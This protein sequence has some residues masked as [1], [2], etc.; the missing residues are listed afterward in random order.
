MCGAIIFGL[1]FGAL[2]LR[3]MKRWAYYHHGCGGGG[4][5][6]GCGGPGAGHGHCGGPRGRRFMYYRWGGAGGGWG[7]GPWG[8]HGQPDGSFAPD[9]PF[10][11]RGAAARPAG[12]PIAEVLRSLELN[13]RQQQEA[14]PVLALAH[15]WLGPSGPRIEAALL[16]VAAE[17]FEPVLVEGLLADA[18]A[19]IQREILDGLEHLHTILISEQRE[20]LRTQLSR[21][22]KAAATSPAPG[23]SGTA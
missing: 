6:H 11:I 1:I 14:A 19:P 12:K 8:G 5:G 20:Q 13:E 17:R 2:T 10:G 3:A 4:L 21:S 9:N 22:N 16:A 15:E 23:D 7:A 18:P